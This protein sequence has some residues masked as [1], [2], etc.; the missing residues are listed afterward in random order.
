MQGGVTSNNR[1]TL[2]DYWKGEAQWR[3]VSSHNYTSPTQAGGNHI[4][5]HDGVWYLFSRRTDEASRPTYCTRGY[6]GI[7]VQSSTDQGAT[8]SSRRPMPP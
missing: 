3:L 2:T 4:T 8:W 1:P 5:V 6:L 7:A